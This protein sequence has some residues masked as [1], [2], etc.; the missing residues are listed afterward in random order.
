MTKDQVQSTE[1]ALK[2]ALEA[3]KMCRGLIRNNIAEGVAISSPNPFFSTDVDAAIT[4]INEALN[5]ASHLAAPVQELV[6]YTVS[7]EVKNWATDFSKYKTRHY[8]RPVY[9]RP[10]YTTPHAAQPAPVQ[11]CKSC[12]GAGDVH[13]QTGEWRGA[14][15]CAKDAQPAPVQK[16]AF[17]GFMDTENCCVHICYTPWAP[18]MTDGKFA[19]AYYT[20]QPAAP[21]QEPVAKRKLIGWRTEDFLRET[22]NIKVAQNWEVHYEVLPVFE[23]DPNTKLTTPPAAQRQWVGLMD[24]EII[25]AMPGGIYDCL[26]DPWDCGVGDGDTLRS[27]KK[28]VLRIARAIEAKLREKNT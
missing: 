16:P 26:N 9:T 10:V 22:T 25:K 21:V 1:E 27:I 5:D 20:A 24:E 18:R 15:H 7:G 2:L 19:T 3:L 11:R 14:C 13:D 17:H 6:A 23:G 12:D 4:A 8:T 28:D